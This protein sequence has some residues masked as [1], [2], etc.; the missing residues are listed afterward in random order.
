M[1]KGRV[2]L[3][4]ALA[5]GA[6]GLA[7]PVHGPVNPSRSGPR[8]EAHFLNVV[9]AEFIDRN[10]S[11]D[12]SAGDEVVLWL[13][14]PLAPKRSV[15]LEDLALVDAGDDWGSGASCRFG[16]SGDRDEVRVLLGEAPHLRLYGTY[17]PGTG[18]TT[19]SQVRSTVGPVPILVRPSDRQAFVGDRF[20]DSGD[21]R[22]YYGQLHAHTG[23]SDGEME[24]ADAFRMARQWG[25]DFFAVTDHLEQ[26]TEDT[27]RR[28]RAAADAAEAP[29]SFVA[30]AGY[31]WGGFATVHGWM[32][33]VNVVGSDRLLG[34]MDTL[35]LGRLYDGIL[36]LPGERVV[37]QFNHPGMKRPVVG[38]NNWNDFEYHADADLRMKLVTVDTNDPTA[39]DNRETTGLIPALDRGWH[40]APKGEEDNHHASWGRSRR[41]TG[42]WIPALTRPEV[43]SGLLRM[44]TFYTDDPDARIKL[45][46][47][48]RWL[49]GSTVYGGG[50]HRLELEVDHRKRVAV[51]SRV[52]LV[53]RGGAVVASRPGGP[54]P[55]RLAF[56]VNPETD[57]YYFARVL[58]EDPD[59][60]L[61]SAPIF[62]DR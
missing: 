2:F 9:A 56:D 22:V 57:A 7:Q 17:R 49:M 15:R 31:E 13:R 3:T 58:L 14:R 10:R 55:L 40:V 1:A 52:E 24:P 29:G 28:S 34:V 45:R 20:P 4:V 50:V 6:V 39:E 41:R 32:N 42:L 60:R 27:W 37:G 48:G 38:G 12:A 8:V 16:P 36:H 5:L 19:V 35:S 11:G 18:G 33:H 62:V 30:L 53:S 26:L 43:L 25:L 54:T 44:A 21:L 46:A 51:V 47:D 61:I 23:F 59:L